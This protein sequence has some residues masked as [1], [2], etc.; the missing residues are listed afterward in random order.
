MSLY[1]VYS[2]DGTELF[3]GSAEELEVAADSAKL[4]RRAVHM[5]SLADPAQNHT[6][7]MSSTPEQ[8]TL[9]QLT[10][11]SIDSNTLVEEY[12]HS[13]AAR[14]IQVTLHCISW[15]LVCSAHQRCI[16]KTCPGAL[17]QLHVAPSEGSMNTMDVQCAESNLGYLSLLLGEMVGGA[18]CRQ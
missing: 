6:A 7:Y 18:H 15:M 8:R 12:T 2:A 13:I 1:G 11:S 17:A 9:Q 4:L 14:A 3:P 5:H 16:V 10:V